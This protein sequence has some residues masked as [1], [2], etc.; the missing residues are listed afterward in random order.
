M[1]RIRTIKPSFWED[2]KIAKLP[3]ACRLFYIG[4]WNQADDMG[5]IRGNPALLKSAIF[6]YDEDLRVSEVQKWIDAL[7]NARM[8]IP[9]TY[10]SESYYIIRTF[11]SHQKFDARY[12]N[13]IIPKEISS[14]ETDDYEHTTCT[15]WVHAG[16]TPREG[17]REREVYREYNT[18][19]SPPAGDVCDDS[20]NKF[21]DNSHKI[22]KEEKEKSSAKK[23]K[24]PNYSFDEFWELYDKK[25]GKKDSLIKKWLKLSDQE[26]ELAM[27][28]I[29]QYKQCQPDKK[30]RKN[31]ETFLNQK[32]W[33]DELIFDHGNRKLSSDNQ[34]GFSK[35]SGNTSGNDAANKRA[36]L[37]NLENLAEAVLR[38]TLP[39]HD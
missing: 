5:V 36:E 4:M 12:P 15:R 16:Y 24:E 6:P 26:R 31:P 25:V 20:E 10:K 8:L 34:V 1:A 18:P 39:S 23:E 32:S 11:R 9:I 28:Y 21:Q 22:S 17:E 29:P 38:G 19:Y 7:V 30:Y 2:E 3:R 13:F 14:K 35:P 33:N 37:D 27:S